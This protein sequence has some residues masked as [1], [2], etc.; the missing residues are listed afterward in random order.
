MKARR[1]SGRGLGRIDPRYC[2]YLD[3]VSEYV[4][5]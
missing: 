1:R 3:G 4:D 5:F 2:M